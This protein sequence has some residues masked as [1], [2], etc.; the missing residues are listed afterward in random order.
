MLDLNFL[1]P[2]GR[3]HLEGK[4]DL[5]LFYYA[6]LRPHQGLGGATPAEVYWRIAPPTSH[7][8]APPRAVSRDPAR[9]LELPFRVAHLDRQ[10]RLPILIPTT[11]AA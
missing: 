7:A 9:P 8:V 6:T 11:L 4:I 1:P 3:R 10:R 2:L 5:G